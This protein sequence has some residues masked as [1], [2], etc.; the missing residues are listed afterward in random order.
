M[1]I[2]NALPLQWWAI[3]QPTYNDQRPGFVRPKPFIQIWQKNDPIKDQVS[4]ETNPSDSFDLEIL[5]RNHAAIARLPY[6]KTIFAGPVISPTLSIQNHDFAGSLSPWTQDDLPYPG[7]GATWNWIGAGNIK[8]D[9]TAGTL[10][11]TKFLRA[12]RADGYGLGWP[13]GHYL[14]DLNGA[15]NHSTGAH[16][17]NMLFEFSGSDDGGLTNTVL[18]T[19]GAV[20]TVGVSTGIGVTIDTTKY[21]KSF[22]FRFY[23]PG[24]TVGPV[25]VN[26]AHFNLPT[27]GVI[28]NLYPPRNESYA[29]H[30]LNTSFDAAVGVSSS[31]FQNSDFVGSLSP[32]IQNGGAG[33][34]AFNWIADNNIFCDGLIPNT[35]K[36]DSL[37]APPFSQ[38]I[39]WLPGTYSIRV[40][41]RNTSVGGVGFGDDIRIYIVSSLDGISANDT[42][43]NTSAF[44]ATG[45]DF[46]YTV[47]IILT[48]PVAY[49][50]VKGINPDNTTRIRLKF[51]HLNLLSFTPS[52]TLDLVHFIIQK[53]TIDVYQTDYLEF[54]SSVPND[55]YNGSRLIYYKN[56]TNYA[57]ID[58]PNDGNYFALRV[59]CKF[60]TER[61]QTTQTGINLT[62]KSID[63]SEFIKFQRWLQIPVMPD[64]MLKKLELILAHSVKGSLLI[65]GIEWTK[66]ESINRSGPGGDIK[67]P[68]QMADIWLTDKNAGVRNII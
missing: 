2:S 10:I 24:A 28:P 62:S 27:G 45:T 35:F 37:Y 65:D 59:P 16:A 33:Q 47:T 38:L 40:R 46:D 20:F 3:D 30:D 54:K 1:P 56:L 68:E 61:T 58:Y 7:F 9:G 15:V 52:P 34:F 25:I 63:T 22:A 64:Y 4:N 8:A 29:R 19:S 60:F 17:A 66:Q 53:N 55:T 67:Y 36:S 14:L 13:I 43:L 11:T 32:W 44:L 42:V 21:W 39:N 6:A 12:V 5:D 49:I 26:V 41:G 50:G 23:I 57:G 51:S 18:Y 31:V 48:T